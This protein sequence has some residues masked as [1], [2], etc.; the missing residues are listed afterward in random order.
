MLFQ[1]FPG[2]RQA[3]SIFFSKCKSVNLCLY[4]ISSR[5]ARMSIPVQTDPYCSADGTRTEAAESN[6]GLSGIAMPM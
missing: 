5:T 4:G 3:V 2:H 6:P 1:A